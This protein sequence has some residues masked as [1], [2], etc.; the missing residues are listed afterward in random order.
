MSLGCTVP[1]PYCSVRSMC[2][3]VSAFVYNIVSVQPLFYSFNNMV[4]LEDVIYGAEKF[5][6]FSLPSLI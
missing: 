5:V 4:I 6:L 2:S 1:K 3:I